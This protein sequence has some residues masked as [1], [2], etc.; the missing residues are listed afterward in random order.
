M[1]RG[2]DRQPELS[3]APRLVYP[4]KAAFTR[5]R[6]LAWLARG[7]P[8]APRGLRILFYH[9]VAD[10]RDEL[11]VVP[12]TFAAQ[13]DELASAGLRAVDVTT[14]IAAL[15][16]GEEAGLVALSFDD[17]YADVAQHALPELE[18]H[19]FS[20]TVFVATAVVDGRASFSWYERQPAVLGWDEIA[21]LDGG[22][23]RFESH[24]ATHPNLL[25]LDDADARAEIEDGKRELE[26]R[27][28]R[29]ST[30]FCYPAGL[31]GPREA[32][33]VRAAGYA[34]ATSCEPGVNGPDADRFA[35]RRTQVDARDGRLD[36]RAKLAG[37]HDAPP[38]LRAAWR[39]ARYGRGSPREASSAR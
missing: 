10:D 36:F 6:S 21:A 32:R 13:M 38:P 37:A 20:A 34:A 25:V 1:A 31:F 5:G 30:V 29:P 27:L 39:R 3:L 16:A 26:A 8:P 22:A 35:L 28:G 17:G 19:G 11:A 33:L 18:R 24:T 15:D 4:A 7:R 14:A 9:R 2:A 12:R 23:L